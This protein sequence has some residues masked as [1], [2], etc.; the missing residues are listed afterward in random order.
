MFDLILTGPG[1]STAENV[2]VQIKPVVV[3][4]SS[5]VNN[6]KYRMVATSVSGSSFL[7]L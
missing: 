1:M 6:T 7:L 2:L 3:K 5:S 4:T